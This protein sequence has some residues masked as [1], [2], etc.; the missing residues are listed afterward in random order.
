MTK[1]SQRV[2][3]S[4]GSQRVNVSEGSQRINVLDNLAANDAI[5]GKI[6]VNGTPIKATHTGSGGSV[7]VMES[8]V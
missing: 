4:E 7:L 5:N 8:V 1:G 3:V 6:A 2:N